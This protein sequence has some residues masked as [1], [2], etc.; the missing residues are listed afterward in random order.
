MV[1][2]IVLISDFLR[3]SDMRMVRVNKQKVGAKRDWWGNSL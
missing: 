2:F 3:S 1:F